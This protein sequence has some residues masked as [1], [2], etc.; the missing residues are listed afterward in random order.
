MV[1]AS[2]VI[3]SDHKYSTV[4]PAAMT[5]ETSI[6]HELTD[7]D[8]AMKH[9]YL[10][11]LYYFRDIAHFETMVLKEPMFRLLVTYF[12][13]AGRIR[14]DDV[15]GRPYIKC[16]DSGIRIVE[17]RCNVSL[18]E[19][20][21]L[22]GTGVVDLEEEGFKHQ[23]VPRHF[24]ARPP[25]HQL[26]PLLLVQFTWFEGGGFSLGLRWSHILGDISTAVGFIN[27]YGKL[28]AGNTI[29]VDKNNNKNDD[30]NTSNR[31]AEST[32]V[33]KQ[34]DTSERYWAVVNK[35]KM[36]TM[37]FTVSKNHLSEIIGSTGTLQMQH[38]RAFE[39][40][41]A[42]I[43]HWMAGIRQDKEP[44]TI[45]IC[46]PTPTHNH[47][48][49][50]NMQSITTVRRLAGEMD[51]GELAAAITDAGGDAA[52]D[53]DGAPETDVILYGANLTFVYMDGV[54]VDG[55]EIQGRKA[56]GVEYVID[57]VGDDGFVLIWNISGGGGTRVTVVLPKHQLGLLSQHICAS[58][59]H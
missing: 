29:L 32:S 23:L 19:W 8:L 1:F 26:S 48:I 59:D 17:A 51:V 21:L 50:S 44:T 18:E 20:V 33:L 49:T 24:I 28:L 58:F 6:V 41:S 36:A 56:V 42:K 13:V 46:R 53:Y 52:A 30:I 45:T 27:H 5:K 35:Q 4:V 22:H 2:D 54:E 12:P 47:G 15:T 16:N 37:S 57:G 11:G 9:H 39:I 14:V 40:I 10:C 31:K 38:Q 25:E 55:L 3:I 34:V 43:W 7:M